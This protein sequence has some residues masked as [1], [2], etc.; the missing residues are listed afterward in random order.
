MVTLRAS[1]GETPVDDILAFMPGIGEREHRLR[2]RIRA[3]RNIAVR[4]LLDLP[5]SGARDLTRSMQQCADAWAYRPAGMEKLEQV[6]AF[7]Q[8]L[9]R[10]VEE[11][12]AVEELS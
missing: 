9:W 1:K 3:A 2:K 11:A 4:S 10:V 12:K 8:S 7:L 6:V 5:D